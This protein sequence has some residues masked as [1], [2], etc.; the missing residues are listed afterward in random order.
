VSKILIQKKDIVVLVVQQV[1]MLLVTYVL[2]AT[3]ADYYTTLELLEQ[4]G[5]LLA[6][7]GMSS[8]LLFLCNNS[9][10]IFVLSIL[11]FQVLPI[12]IMKWKLK[13][14]KHGIYIVILGS[15][16]QITLAFGIVVIVLSSIVFSNHGY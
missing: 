9:S 11:L 4:K 14:E 8:I 13:E 1:I 2:Y 6:P 10:I 7:M 15:I 5:S 12:V 16:S 3:I